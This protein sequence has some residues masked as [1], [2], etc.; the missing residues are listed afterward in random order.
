VATIAIMEFRRLIPEDLDQAQG[1]AI[2]GLRPELYPMRLDTGKIRGA[3]QHFMSSTT[4]FHLVALDGGRIV[5]GIAAAV[6]ESPWFERC[7]AMVAMFRATVPGVG[8]ALLAALRSW[9]DDSMRIRRVLF[10]L[11]FDAR[12]GMQRLVRR[13][14][15]N[16][17]QLVCVFEKD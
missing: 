13:Y 17:T 9:I 11:E 2:E 8:A 15:F 16:R 4:D 1:F 3:L 7:D 12:P 5:G 14:G 10:P 6:Y